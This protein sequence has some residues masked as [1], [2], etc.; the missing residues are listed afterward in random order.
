MP[1]DPIA[2]DIREMGENVAKLVAKYDTL[3]PKTYVDQQFNTL[4]QK[5]DSY[6]ADTASR[7]DVLTVQNGINNLHILMVE[8]LGG[9]A[10]RGD[11]MTRQEA[12][13]RF[14]E[15]RNN[16]ADTSVKLNALLTNSSNR[17]WDILKTMIPW[18]VVGAAL[19]ALVGYGHLSL[20]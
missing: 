16:Q 12:D 18:A 14:S 8:R 9:V 11:V 10:A 6:R 5:I 4:S 15:L 20:H 17:V 13:A 7:A 2:Q 1:D 19:S 3:A